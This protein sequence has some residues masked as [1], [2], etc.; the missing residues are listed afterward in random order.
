MKRISISLITYIVLTGVAAGQTYLPAGGQE[1]AGNMRQSTPQVQNTYV[2]NELVTARDTIKLAVN[3]IN[4]LRD[5]CAKLSAE[6]ES[7]NTEITKIRNQMAKLS[8]AEARNQSLQNEI[9]LLRGQYNDGQAQNQALR[10]R[11]TAVETSAQT[12]K[13]MQLRLEGVQKESENLRNLLA[14]ADNKA[15]EATNKAL[16]LEK[17]LHET[18][19]VAKQL[20]EVSARETQLTLEVEKL[21]KQRDEMNQKIKVL[22]DTVN[23]YK[24]LESSING[25]QA[26]KATLERNLLD[27]KNLLESRNKEYKKVF[28]EKSALATKLE[29]VTKN[30]TTAQTAL[31]KA[32]EA[33][34]TKEKAI[35]QRYEEELVK[36]N[37]A[38]EK[39]IAT[40]KEL[41][42][43]L[44]T[45]NAEKESLANKVKDL[46]AQYDSS[47][48]DKKVTE[49]KLIQEN[50]S[51][52]KKL[53]EMEQN[54]QAAE[55]SH[56]KQIESAQ[57]KLAEAE[58]AL[59]A[60]ENTATALRSKIQ[61]NE[62]TNACS[63]I[64]IKKQHDK[65]TT[66]YDKLLN[67]NK[68]L[69]NALK[70][71]NTLAQQVTELQ[72]KLSIAKENA[73]T[74]TKNTI[75]R[76]IYNSL[77]TE[78]E[79]LKNTYTT[80]EKKA[81]EDQNKSTAE[82]KALQSKIADLKQKLDEEYTKNA[83]LQQALDDNEKSSKIAS[84][85]FTAQQKKL[86]AAEKRIVELEQIIANKS[87]L[88]EE[89]NTTKSK[90]SSHA[91]QLTAFKEEYIALREK[92][93]SETLTRA[94]NEDIKIQKLQTLLDETKSAKEELK[95]KLNAKNAKI[96]ELEAEL[97]KSH[98]L[99]EELNLSIQK[100]QASQNAL[101][102]K[103]NNAVSENKAAEI[104]ELTSEIKIL[105]KALEEKTTVINDQQI[106]L[107]NMEKALEVGRR[108]QVPS[109]KVYTEKKEEI[110]PVQKENDNK[111]DVKITHTPNEILHKM[112]EN[113]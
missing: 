3:K 80:I 64:E 90:L 17:Q 91:E 98:N 111:H 51:L 86:D 19:T 45:L 57:N 36:S 54:K 34:N 38:K 100:L 82:N 70:E 113:N 83:S 74:A 85:N 44:T 31:A 47:L 49:E 78:H 66:D 93:Q 1:Y 14:K 61:E 2:R 107:S 71:K 50:K 18:E 62:K 23:T 13:D 12:L 26:E 46:N 73:E 11:L 35:K 97:E 59:L 5:Q 79:N 92:I 104:A 67:E 15:I 25:I 58:K 95:I 10:A 21:K 68:E 27:T 108:T 110:I 56:A 40:L 48:K 53:K 112:F 72:K 55:N 84:Q 96:T 32:D 102:E 81:K 9:D 30:Y 37:M 101:K 87:I 20:K 8:N 41:E 7:K 76:D 43:R 29:K 94:K 77:K 89:L 39:A 28:E 52:H 63:Y 24:E 60:A 88:Q 99:Q 33:L 69:E 65:L 42:G 105:K 103:A 75:D 22:C 6:L 16:N 109:V 4:I 106:A